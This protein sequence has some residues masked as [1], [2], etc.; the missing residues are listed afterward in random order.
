MIVPGANLLG[1]ALKIIKPQTVRYYQ[2]IGRTTNDVGKDVTIFAA[3]VDVIGGSVQAVP[4]ERFE[5]LGLNRQKRYVAWFAPVYAVGVMRGRSGDQFVY[6]NLRY[7]VVAEAD[8]FQQDGWVG[9]VGLMI[10]NE[11]FP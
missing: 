5:Q 8:W 11:A 6:G 10:G 1:L 4:L 3:P 2:D 9:V 7:E